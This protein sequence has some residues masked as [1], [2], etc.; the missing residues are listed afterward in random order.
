MP[1]ATLL[2]KHRPRREALAFLRYLGPGLLVTVGFIDP[3]NWA[4]NIAA[5]SL[6]G[7]DLLWI[8]TL[9]TIMLAVLQHNA[10]HLGIATG[11][12]LA[13]AATHHLRP[14]VSRLVLGSA[15]L[16]AISTAMAEILGAALGLSLL[17][18]GLPYEAAAFLVLAVAL[19]LLFGNTYPH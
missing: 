12:C 9:G 6:H 18:P 10:A 17:I 7:Y 16:A 11:E 14:G 4:A 13:E 5:G 15:V 8:V 2:E 19:V 3:G 1:L